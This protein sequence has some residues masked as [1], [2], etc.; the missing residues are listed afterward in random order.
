MR[1]VDLFCGIGGVPEAARAVE[2]A[3][4]VAAIDI[5]RTSNEGYALNH[6]IH[7]RC[8]TLESIDA[9]AP[10][11]LLWLSPPCQPYTR[12]GNQNQEHDPRSHALSHLISIIDRDPPAALI[13]ENVPEFLDSTHHRDLARILDRHGFATMHELLCP[14]Q[15]GIPMRRRRFYLRAVRGVQSLA[16]IQPVAE[17]R[18]MKVFLDEAAWDD[19]EL[20][21]PQ[22]LQECYAAAMDIVEADR[23][24]SIAACFTSAYG[25]SPVRA[26][27]YLRS[28]RRNHLRRFSPREIA[29]LMGYR[30]DFRWPRGTSLRQRYRMIGNALSVQVTR[31]LMNASC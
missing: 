29:R 1:I 17:C 30:D 12:R 26:G 4:V 27:S 25:N 13:L 9:I 18:P 6:R 20:R 31:A 5:D 14:T 3:S 24:D 22:S 10:C 28:T 15:W 8:Q 19:A 2:S 7:P 11:D 16:P 21:V 23:T